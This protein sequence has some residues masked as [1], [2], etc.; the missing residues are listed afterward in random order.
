MGSSK[1]FPFWLPSQEIRTLRAKNKERKSTSAEEKPRYSSKPRTKGRVSSKTKTKIH[2][3]KLSLAILSSDYISATL[4]TETRMFTAKKKP[5]Q[6]LHCPVQNQGKLAKFWLKGSPFVLLHSRWAAGR[7][8]NWW[9]F[10]YFNS[11]NIFGELKE[12]T[13]QIL[14]KKK[15]SFLLDERGKA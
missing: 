10:K 15:K 13:F 6:K 4:H 8:L 1:K 12:C 7:R 5:T 11:E 3:W 2:L 14:E 9:L